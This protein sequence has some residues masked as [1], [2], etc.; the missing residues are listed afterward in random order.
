MWWNKK[1]NRYWIRVETTN[2]NYGLIQIGESFA[3]ACLNIEKDEVYS[4]IK[5]ELIEIL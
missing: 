4:C 1:K 5:F 2:S 3:D